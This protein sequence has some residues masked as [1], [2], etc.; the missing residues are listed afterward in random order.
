MNIHGMVVCVNYLD[1]LQVG[2]S[3]WLSGLNSLTVVTAPGDAAEKL[4]DPKIKVVVTDAFYRNGA[5]FNKGLAM[6]EAIASVPW[7]DWVLLFDADIVPPMEWYREARGCRRQTLYGAYRFQVDAPG[8]VDRKDLP[9]IPDGKYELPGFFQLFHVTAPAV[10]RKPIFEANWLHAGN[11]DT[12]FQARWPQNYRV[13]L[14]IRLAHIGATGNWWGRG[15]EA[16]SKMKAMYEERERRRGY[17]HEVV[18][19]NRGANPRHRESKRMLMRNDEG[20]AQCGLALFS[21]AD[22]AGRA[23]FNAWRSW[24]FIPRCTVAVFGDAPDVVAGVARLGLKTINPVERNER[25]RPRLDYI[26]ETMHQR[27]NEDVLGYV[28]SDITILPGLAETITTVR[29]ELEEFLIV[30]R[31]WNVDDLPNIDFSPGWDDVTREFVLQHGELC[32]PYAIDLFVFSRGVCRDLPPFALGNDAWDNHLVM[33]ARRRGIPVVDVTEQV[34]LVHQNHSLGQYASQDARLRS[35]DSLR[36]FVWMGGSYALLGRTSDA[37]HRVTDGRLQF[38]ETTAVTV[39]LPHRGDERVLCRCLRAIEHQSY[40]RSYID[41]IAVN[42]DPCAALRYLEADFPL[43]RVV[44]EYRPGPAS[45]RNTGISLAKGE[46]VA[47]FDS[48]TVPDA[49]CIEQAVRVLLDRP[50]CEIV[51][52][53]IAPAFARGR[54]GYLRRAVE[55]FDAVSHYNSEQWL[56]HAGGFATGALVVRKSV[57]EQHGYFDETFQEASYEDWEW[58]T[59]VLSAGVNA[60]FCATAVVSHQAAGTVSEL[61]RK[62]QRYSRG[63]CLFRAIE[64]RG[65]YGVSAIVRDE[66]KELVGRLRAACRHPRI[67]GHYR[68]GVVLVAVFCFVWMLLEKLRYRHKAAR[69]ARRRAMARQK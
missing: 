10:Q 39:V 62:K 31:R 28:N 55:W 35:P 64:L 6:E 5:A 52:C 17:R 3:R 48:D 29:S 36:N 27:T 54:V 25:G 56:K 63:S 33:R 46:I 20:S 16:A 22:S 45:A 61:R 12:H 58:A 4:T 2:L 32:S 59:R 26:F 14:P 49:R 19:Y 44:N 51:L 21:C 53:K 67:P 8:E 50:E 24:T 23:Q 30:A 41:V 65:G 60:E 68:P 18:S 15:P 1:V 11:Y 40:P 47:L 43:L 38:A 66:W 7:D 57:F 9:D 37:T 69:R 13:K 34:M 42:N